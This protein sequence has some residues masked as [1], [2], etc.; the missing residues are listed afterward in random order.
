MKIVYKLT[1]IVFFNFFLS[2]FEN[3]AAAHNAKADF[4][5]AVPNLHALAQH[6]RPLPQELS[7]FDTNGDG[8]IDEQEERICMAALDTYCNSKNVDKSRM[9]GLLRSYSLKNI[10]P[11]RL[12]SPPLPAFRTAAVENHQPQFRSAPAEHHV[13]I[14][15][16]RSNDQ[17][18]STLGFT[19]I[20]LQAMTDALKQSDLQNTNLE[21][22]NVDKKKAYSA[23]GFTAVLGLATTLLV[24]YL[25]PK[26]C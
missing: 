9:V 1:L 2:A 26:N 24:H 18:S 10:S 13:A 16:Q 5:L 19:A 20:L 4:V 12:T 11:L 6:G 3:G 23:T 17:Q 8:I 7:V 25:S 22:N 15:S 21:E 14:A